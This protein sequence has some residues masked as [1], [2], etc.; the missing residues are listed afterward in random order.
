[1]GPLG[2]FRSRKKINLGGTTFFF[3]FILLSCCPLLPHSLLS[4]ISSHFLLSFFF[5]IN[6]SVCFFC[7]CDKLCV[8]ADLLVQSFSSVLCEWSPQVHLQSLSPSRLML[9]SH[10][11]V[12][13]DLPVSHNAMGASQCTQYCIEFFPLVY[14][15]FNFFQ[16][17]FVIFSV[18]VI[19]LKIFLSVVLFFY[20]I[21][22]GSLLEE[23]PCS[24]TSCSAPK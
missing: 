19:Y 21:V 1:M 4:I 7:Y 22:N 24:F 15:V 2:R 9:C 12:T 18:Q 17:C 20:F 11:R 8:R 16:Q 13:G 3:K 6:V 5:L 23:A 14:I 10:G